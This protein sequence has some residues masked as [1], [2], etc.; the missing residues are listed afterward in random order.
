MGCMRAHKNDSYHYSS[1]AV[2]VWAQ[3]L[4]LQIGSGGVLFFS[5]YRWGGMDEIESLPDGLTLSSGWK[6]MTILGIVQIALAVVVGICVLATIFFSNC[7]SCL[8][9]IIGVVNSL[10]CLACTVVSGVYLYQGYHMANSFFESL[11]NPDEAPDFNFGDNQVYQL[12]IATKG[13]MLLGAVLSVAAL[14]PFSRAP[15]TTPADPTPEVILYVNCLAL[16]LILGITLVLP[17]D[18]SDAIIIGGIWIGITAVVAVLSGVL[19]CCS[20][21][22]VAAVLGVCFLCIAV[23]SAISVIIVG[24]YYSGGRIITL[25]ASKADPDGV[26]SM[27]LDLEK[28]ANIPPEDR[29]YFLMFQCT[30]QGMFLLSA[31]VTAFAIFALSV[32]SAIYFLR[33]GCDVKDRRSESKE[34]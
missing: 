25:N 32:F 12:Y 5:G 29:D 2:G 20:R 13:R 28:V 14:A 11:W 24:V 23:Y 6:V 4:A 22:I 15:T 33:F 27:V 21:G 34:F 17:M 18:V 19:N 30:D 8:L 26:T 9:N 3:G 10:Y 16:C 7:F 31:I 1:G